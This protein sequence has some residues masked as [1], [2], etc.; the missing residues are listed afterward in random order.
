MSQIWG[1]NVTLFGSD[2]DSGVS[3]GLWVIHTG[4]KSG[5]DMVTLFGSDCFDG[6]SADIGVIHTGP[7]SGGKKSH[8]LAVTLIVV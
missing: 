5:G 6:V 4:P 8:F 7:K 3:A 2:F 1:R